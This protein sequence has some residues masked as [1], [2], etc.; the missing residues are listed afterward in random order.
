MYQLDPA[1]WLFFRA[2][3]TD[4]SA[5]TDLVFN[6]AGIALSVVK[7]TVAP[8]P[9]TLSASSNATDWAAGKLWKV[10]GNLYR[11]GIGT[12]SIVG[13]SGTIGVAGSFTGDELDPVFEEVTAYNPSKSLGTPIEISEQISDDWDN[14][15]TSGPTSH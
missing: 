13:F 6:T 3:N 9:L 8:S 4:G 15:R 11:V 7:K 12:A 2:W 10:N 5:K 1:P 14:E